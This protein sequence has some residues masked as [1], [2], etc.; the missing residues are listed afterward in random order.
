MKTT[1]GLWDTVKPGEPLILRPS[2]GEGEIATGLVRG[3]LQRHLWNIRRPGAPGGPT[4]KLFLTSSTP[5]SKI[6]DTGSPEKFLATTETDGPLAQRCRQ[7]NSTDSLVDR[8][9]LRVVLFFRGRESNVKATP[10]RRLKRIA[11]RAVC[12]GLALS[13]G[14]IRAV[15]GG[16]SAVRCSHVLAGD[17]PLRPAEAEALSKF[18]A[19]R[20]RELFA[21]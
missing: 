10:E 11:R 2:A 13:P 12:L 21:E 3:M 4:V 15:C 17:V 1:V 18:A 6:S 8:C 9:V 19:R 16:M 7:G 5:G 14:E 20:L